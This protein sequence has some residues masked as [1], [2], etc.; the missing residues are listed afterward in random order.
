MSTYGWKVLLLGDSQVGKSQLYHHYSLSPV[1]CYK[2]SIGAQI[3]SRTFFL[4]GKEW[5]IVLW[6][7]KGPALAGCAVTRFFSNCN[8][9]IVVF[10]VGSR[11]SFESVTKWCQSIWTSAGNDAIILLVGN[12]RNNDRKVSTEE[13][14]H[15]AR[16]LGLPFLEVSATQD[17]QALI[18]FD[19]ISRMIVKQAKRLKH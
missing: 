13:G 3:S 1:D 14:I 5:M 17:S 12:R 16:T 6:D 7:A 4:D 15:L 9:A 11:E 10:D 18:V 19:T 2:S 8:A